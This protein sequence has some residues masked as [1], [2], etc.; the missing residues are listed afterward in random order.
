MIF[1]FIIYLYLKLKIYITGLFVKNSK[2][3]AINKI[4]LIYKIHLRELLG[5]KGS[6]NNNF[7]FLARTKVPFREETVYLGRTLISCWVGAWGEA[8]E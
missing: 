6:K 4:D 3:E 2:I 7:I 5:H 8:P 1:F